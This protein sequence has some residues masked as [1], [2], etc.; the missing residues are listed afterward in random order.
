MSPSPA[1][2]RPSAELPSSGWITLGRFPQCPAQS[3]PAGS[4]CSSCMIGPTRENVIDA[5]KRRCRASAPGAASAPVPSSRMSPSTAMRRPWPSGFEAASSDSAAAHR[6]RARIVGLVEQGDRPG[7]QHQTARCAPRP[8]SA[9]RPPKA[10]A[11]VATS[12]AQRLHRREDREAVLRLMQ[13]GK[14]Q[15]IAHPLPHHF[16]DDAASVGE[17]LQSISVRIGRIAAEGKDVR[18][19]APLGMRDQPVVMRDCRAAE[20]RCR[21]HPCRP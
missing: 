1:R 6:S 14:P 10:E 16:G 4:R 13:A 20:P 15:R 3:S 19:A 8:F 11:A 7:D 18:D 5:A 9:A 2:H 17:M 12:R 21:P